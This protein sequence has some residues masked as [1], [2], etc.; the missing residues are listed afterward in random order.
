MRNVVTWACMQRTG[1]VAVALLTVVLV[2][3]IASIQTVHVT[4]GHEEH[5]EVAA[6]VRVAAQRLEDGAVQFG[7]RVR[8]EN[9]VWAE[10]V[11]PR[12]H[13]FDPAK[14]RTGRWLVSSPLTVEVN[15]AGHG[16]LVRSER[17]EPAPRG[18]V[19]LATGLEEWMWDAHISAYHDEDGKLLTR[20]MI[21][22]KSPGAPDGEIRTIVT[23]Q[24][25]ELSVN[26]G[27]LPNPTGN[28]AAARAGQQ[29]SVSWSVDE[30]ARQSEHR[31]VAASATGL[32]LVQGAES[33]LA[34]ALFGDGSLL[35][36]SIGTAPAMDAN[37]DLD[38]FRALTVYDNLRYCSGGPELTGHT[39]LR[40][41]AQ[42]RDDQRIEF[43]VQQR[44]A[45]GWSDNIL[46]RARIINAFGD[47]TNWRSS[48]PVRVNVE[49]HPAQQIVMPYPAVRPAFE[50]I[51]PS[52]RSAPYSAS[53]SYEVQELEL[54][55]H[56]PAKLNSVVTVGNE[57]GLR[58]QMGCFGDDRRVLLTGAP[59]DATGDL[60]L[61]FD[62]TQL[63]A[64]WGVSADDHT[65]TLSPA[66]HERVIHRLRQAQMLSV[67]L[68]TGAA[69]PISFD[70]SDLFEMPIQRN[71][72]H[73]G[74]YTEPDW[75][76]VIEAQ[77]GLTEGGVAYGVSYPAW[78]GFQR[79][80]SVS[81]RT[82][83]DATASE[84]I[85]PT[86]SMTCNTRTL[87]YLI[88]PLPDV[89]APTSIRLRIDDGEWFEQRVWI[90]PG[91]DGAFTAA[92]NADPERFRQGTVLEFEIGQEQPFQGSLDLG[93][94]FDTPI[95]VNFDNCLIPYWTTPKAYVPVADHEGDAPP[96]IRYFTVQDEDGSVSTVI[97][98]QANE[99]PE[100]GAEFRLRTQCQSGSVLTAFV[101]VPLSLEAREVYVTMTIDD[102]LPETSLWYTQ[103][104][105]SDTLILPPSAARLTSQI[106]EASVVV[107]EIPE[108]SAEP[109]VVQVS[110]MFDTPLQ[111]NI[112][113]CG[114]YAPGQSRMSVPQN[115]RDSELIDDADSGLRLWRFRQR[116]P[117]PGGIPYHQTLESRFRGDVV[118]IGVLVT[119]GSS[120]SELAIYGSAVDALLEDHTLVAWST[121]GGATGRATWNVGQ[122]GG[123]WAAYPLRAK[124]VIAAWRHA[125]ELELTLLGASSTTYHFDL[126]W[127]FGFSDIHTLDDCLAEQLP[128]QSLAV[129][130]VP[131]SGSSDIGY[132]VKAVR[133]SAWIS[134]FVSARDNREATAEGPDT[135]PRS[136]AV[137]YCTA[138]GLEFSIANL[139][140]AESTSIDGDKV[141]VSWK[142][143]GQWY[144]E[145]WDVWTDAFVYSIS[146]PD[147][148]AF[149]KEL[150]GAETLTIRVL[151]DP[152]ITKTFDLGRHG[153]WDTPVQPNLDACAGS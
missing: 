95:Q 25:G 69:A 150:R 109:F 18:S 59:A 94:L 89:G 39:E 9:G 100:F 22:S 47:A 8:D 48:T 46:P 82:I 28:G 42:V 115:I 4:R 31:A 34:E 73:C 29:L 135:S 137:I 86:F 148:V 145:I 79:D 77:H 122:T 107:L 85:A 149:Y 54:E 124:P 102:G 127:L 27:G 45:D 130:D 153:F 71:I 26:I 152:Q 76:P 120:G 36:L 49:L 90:Y 83:S 106:R 93:V 125:T 11:T 108:L 116:I 68:G 57:Q 119:C 2:V 63:T 104:V 141:E 134:S 84:Q 56:W 50:P 99:H 60:V 15:D 20:A 64:T 151:S 110:A 143:D 139:E 92:F 117:S 10:P 6:Q 98:A 97:L 74:N 113:E 142:V 91:E 132:M 44:T 140:R 80:S 17:F 66:D 75:Q 30:G 133:G 138:A 12:A 67:K 32:E 72:D 62:D 61:S 78:T 136:S 53:L 147:D 88:E 58:L 112:D 7:L 103:V 87:T 81:V 55:G 52:M 114:Y 70:V 129:W 51:T 128:T 24:G 16:E 96:N 111:Q 43:A 33:G 105:S 118:E 144:D 121:D 23:C 21:Y 65:A 101:E 3:G 35:T 13:R 5:A 126:A 14:V 131:L 146:P 19:L 1:V 37:I 123:L 41:R 40:I 38:A